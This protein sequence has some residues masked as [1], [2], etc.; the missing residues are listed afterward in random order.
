ML[1]YAKEEV[2][3]RNQIL[4][5]YFGEKDTKPCGKCDICLKRKETELSNDDFE[6][7]QQTIRQILNNEELTINALV[8][9][10]PF[11]EPKVLKV[12]RFM[13]DNGQLQENDLMKIQ[14]SK[15]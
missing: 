9:K 13:M 5:T 6:T 14:L 2:I 15:K 12:I 10:V 4:L 7:I 1:D 11:K 3:C 8:R